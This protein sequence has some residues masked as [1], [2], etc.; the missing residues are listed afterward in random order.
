MIKTQAKNLVNFSIL[1][2]NSLEN[3]IM[4]YDP[5]YIM[6]KWNKYIGVTPIQNV[7]KDELLYVFS[8]LM[9]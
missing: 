9:P 1:M 8:S 6:E 7:N 2:H 5:E 3:G 4:G